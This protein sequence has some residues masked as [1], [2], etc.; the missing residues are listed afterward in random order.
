[1]A[2]GGWKDIGKCGF[3]DG[4][5]PLQLRNTCVKNFSGFVRLPG[6]GR[7]SGY[8]Y[9]AA[10]QAKTACCISRLGLGW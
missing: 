1:M 2:C 3:I 8:C 9:L 5:D 7:G 4:Q 10:E 6:F